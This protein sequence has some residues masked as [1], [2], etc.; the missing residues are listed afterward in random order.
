MRV[1]VG[2]DAHAFAAERKL[3]LGGVTIRERDGLAGHSDADVVIHAIADALL[4][5]AAA[6]DLGQVF[7]AEEKWK[8]VSGAELLDEVRLLLAN[9]GWQ[10]GNVDATVI[11]ESPPL[12][13]Y[14]EEMKSNIATALRVSLD[15]ISIKAT[16]SDG[17]GFVGRG[18]G[19][20]AL[21]IASLKEA[22]S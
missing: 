5:A 16:T 19:I 13:P 9:G 6:G 12:A 1:G 15:E 17:L 21:A 4:G 22:R 18:E 7:P 3:I 8:D 20:A 14:R 11:A 2:Y 10:I